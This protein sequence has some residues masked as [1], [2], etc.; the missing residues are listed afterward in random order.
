[1]STIRKTKKLIIHPIAFFKDRNRKIL[2]RDKLIDSLMKSKANPKPKPK[3][4]KQPAKRKTTKTILQS[5]LNGLPVTN[6]DL[7]H[8]EVALYFFG[9]LGNIYQIQ[10]WIAPLRV[11]N[12]SKRLIIIVRTDSVYKWLVKNTDFTAVFCRTID[13]LTYVYETN[14]IKCV[15]YVNHGFK[16]FQSLITG[17]ALHVHINHGE[18]DKISTITNQSKA[19][20]YTFIVGD[21]AYDKYNLNLIKKD[22]DKFIAVGRPQ[23]DHIER[24]APFEVD[25]SPEGIAPLEIDNSPESIAPLKIDNSPE[26][27][28][29]LEI[30]GSLE[31]SEQEVPVN[32]KVILYAPTWE[33]THESMNFS[34]ITEYGMSLVQQIINHPEYYLVYKPHPNTGSR[35]LA[36]KRTNIA[37][38]K[39]VN[40]H[41]SGES[42]LNG[43][44]NSL[45]DHVDLAIFDNSAVAID[46]LQVDKPMIMTDLFYRVRGQYT[47]PT[48]IGAAK[49]ISNSDS[50]SITSIIKEE[51]TIDTKKVQRNKLRKY[52]L[53]DF[54]YSKNESTDAF[55][56]KIKEIIEERDS[57][58][59]DLASMNGNI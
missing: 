14:N 34:S 38:I 53:G 24:I 50:Y 31:N 49:M 19:Y 51:L 13:D 56:S 40:E 46:Y 3:P 2:E 25:N 29:P 44:I 6:I 48:I 1:M 7:R 12:Q 36:C 52:F 58:V 42:I 23:L 15:L 8:Y 45:Y 59:E 18:S 16:N 21:A 39:L 22:M 4:A 57:L 17:N 27:I 11:L 41:N 10:Q 32:K 54:D 43:D 37:I 30:D 28:E 33:G 5:L 26:G 9:G 55:V 47:K 20:D 35:D